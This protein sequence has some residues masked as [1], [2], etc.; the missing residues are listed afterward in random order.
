MARVPLT[1]QISG[2]APRILIVRVGAMGDVLHALPAVA[3]LRAQLPAAFIGWAIEPRWAPLLQTAN[4]L[5]GTA[6][7]PLVD[8]VH[9]VPTR[10]WSRQPFS[11]ATLGSIRRLRRQLRA[12]RY[13]VAIDLQG[14]IRSAVLCRLSGAPVILGPATPREAP[15]RWLYTKPVH[16]IAAHVIDQAAEIVHAALPQAPATQPLPPAPLPSDVAAEAWAANLLGDRAAH[17]VVLAPTA[18][19]GAKEWPAQQFGELAAA[20][21]QRG[22][23]VCINSAGSDRIAAM[24]ETIARQALPDLL[25]SSV[26]IVSTTIPQLI[27]LLRGSALLV[28]GDTG[29]LHLAAALGTP[30]VALF[31][32]TSPDRNGPYF[33]PAINLRDPASVT[34]HR[35]H[36]TTEPGL[37]RISVDAVLQ[38]ALTLLAAGREHVST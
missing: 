35:R 20:M 4:A 7:M 27:A 3:Q 10:D 34:D 36:S 16:T 9:P 33:K 15:A 29:P 30:V 31:G 11:S 21:V 19:W 5:A 2:S 13:T 8:R 18:G 17:T 24:V 6:G 26:H 28:A 12:E 22:Y 37:Q 23:R 1:D 25:Q 32:P 14:S 38:A